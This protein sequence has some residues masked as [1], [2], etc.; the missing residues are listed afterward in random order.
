MIR[1]RAKEERRYSGVPKTMRS[2]IDVLK[3]TAGLLNIQVAGCCL[4]LNY[5]HLLQHTPDGNIS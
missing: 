2:L 5:Y 1:S 3:E 4:M